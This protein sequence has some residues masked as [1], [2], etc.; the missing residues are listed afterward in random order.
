MNHGRR[1]ASLLA[2]G[3]LLLQLTGCALDPL[4]TP[5]ASM[6]NGVKLKGANFTPAAIGPFKLDPAIDAGM[7]TMLR[8][9]A[10]TVVPPAGT[11]FSQYLSDTLKA[12]LEGAGLYDP[13]SKTVI[14]GTLTS[15]EVEST[16]LKSG[17]VKL[18]ARFVV[19]RDGVTRYDRVLDVEKTWSNATN[20]AE[21]VIVA[22]GEYEI[23]HKRLIGIL[24]DDAGFRKAMSKE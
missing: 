14:S 5:R 9:K 3:L 20:G 8:V 16:M 1:I 18:G 13:A 23:F 17:R 2:G 7:D 24:F 10:R 19:T 4:Q 21:F 11:T 15:N 12:E 22:R 6:I